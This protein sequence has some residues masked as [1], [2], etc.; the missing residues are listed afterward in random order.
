M[1]ART[2]IA[3]RVFLSDI[4]KALRTLNMCGPSP[5]V[6]AGYVCSLTKLVCLNATCVE[7][8]LMVESLEILIVFEHPVPDYTCSN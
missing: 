8:T 4:Q 5:L 1:S 2:S 7:R 3:Q 6:L